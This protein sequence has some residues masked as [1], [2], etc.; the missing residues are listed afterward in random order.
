MGDAVF[1]W[2]VDAAC[3]AAGVVA[4]PENGKLEPSDGG[5]MPAHGPLTQFGRFDPEPTRA[6]GR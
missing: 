6:D 4:G 2:I 1:D 3:I 5:F